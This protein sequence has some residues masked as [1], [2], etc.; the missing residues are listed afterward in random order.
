MNQDAVFMN[1]L[2]AVFR[3]QPLYQ[4][5]R[6]LSGVREEET[7][8]P[9]LHESNHVTPGKKKRFLEAHHPFED[10]QTKVGEAG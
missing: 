2:R 5:G 8:M 6:S 7:W 10:W 4:D 1:S 3:M 9:T